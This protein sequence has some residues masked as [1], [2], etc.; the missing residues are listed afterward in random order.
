MSVFLLA[1]RNGSD[2]AGRQ[3]IGRV[4]ARRSRGGVQE[5]RRLRILSVSE[6]LRDSADGHPA[7]TFE[8]RRPVPVHAIEGECLDFFPRI[9]MQL[10]GRVGS[11]QYGTCSRT[12]LSNEPDLLCNCTVME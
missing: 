9:S 2:T 5:R 3:G 8:S 6:P 11:L 10:Q 4:I 7:H 1:A 12:C